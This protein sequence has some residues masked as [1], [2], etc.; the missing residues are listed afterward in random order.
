MLMLSP[1]DVGYI[2][3]DVADLLVLDGIKDSVTDTLLEFG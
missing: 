3:A 1:N 2:V